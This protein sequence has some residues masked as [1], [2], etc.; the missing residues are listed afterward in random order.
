MVEMT[1]EMAKRFGQRRSEYEPDP[2]QSALMGHLPASCRVEMPIKEFC[3]DLDR[4]AD[5]LCELANEVRRIKRYPDRN[6]YMEA[7]RLHSAFRKCDSQ[8]KTEHQ[9]GRYTGYRLSD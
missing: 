2:F 8:I 3:G 5:M 1:E 6:A 7:S 9:R 4:V